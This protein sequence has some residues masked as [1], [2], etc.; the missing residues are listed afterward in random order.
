MTGEIN[1]MKLL[2][3]M[4][5]IILDEEYVFCTINGAK[6]GDYSELSPLASYLEFE[7]LT[8]LLTKDNAEK[9]NLKYEGVFKGITLT[10]HSSLEAVGLTAAISSKLAE[11]GI[12][13]NV[14][15]AYYHDHIF[16]QT[17]KAEMAMEALN[18]FGS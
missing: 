11:K 17:E 10:V 12:S 18:E 14:I 8:L 2:A 16:V 3:S 6:Y 1:L 9:A 5:P 7:G 4:K 15:A 13:A